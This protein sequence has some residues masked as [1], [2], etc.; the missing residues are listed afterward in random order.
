MLKTIYGLGTPVRSVPKPVRQCSATQ[1]CRY[2]LFMLVSGSAVWKAALYL[3]GVHVFRAALAA[4]FLMFFY[5]LHRRS[6]IVTIALGWTFRGK[7]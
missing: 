1:D 3:Q 7:P 5:S 6:P 4:R 2:A